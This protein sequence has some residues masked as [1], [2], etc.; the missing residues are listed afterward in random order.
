MNHFHMQFTIEAMRRLIQ[1]LGISHL[2]PRPLHPHAG[3]V[4]QTQFRDYVMQRVKDV[5]P[6][7]LP[8]RDV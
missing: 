4:A 2:S 7:G 8:L 5:I 6:D 1:R 3:H